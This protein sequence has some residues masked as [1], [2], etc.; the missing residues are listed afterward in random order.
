MSQAEN[1]RQPKRVLTD[2]FQSSKPGLVRKKQSGFPDQSDDVM[3]GLMNGPA[4]ARK[5]VSDGYKTKTSLPA[6]RGQTI[7][8]TNPRDFLESRAYNPE[9]SRSKRRYDDVEPE[10]VPV[11]LNESKLFFMPKSAHASMSEESDDFHDAAFLRPKEE[12]MRDD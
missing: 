10:D 11:T 2:Y 1:E 4:R 3:V 8:S 5:A 6:Y 7:G 9:S 12:V